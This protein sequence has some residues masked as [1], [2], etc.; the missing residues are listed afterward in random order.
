MLVR[1]ARHWGL[2]NAMSHQGGVD[3]GSE[4]MDGSLNR[5]DLRGAVAN[6]AECIHVTECEA[7]LDQVRSVMEDIPAFCRCKP[8]ILALKASR[9]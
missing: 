2:M 9:H 7:F 5:S 8:M 3:L 6:C 4:Y 1:L